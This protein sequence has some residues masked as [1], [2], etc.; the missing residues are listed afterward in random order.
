M[1]AI[2]KALVANHQG[3]G[4]VIYVSDSTF[5]EALDSVSW[6]LDDVGL[7]DA[8]DGISVWEGV[9]QTIWVTKEESDFVLKGTFRQP[10]IEEWNHLASG[11]N[12]WVKKRG[13]KTKHDQF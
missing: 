4:I 8:P 12:P 1:V 9:M 2:R 3:T 6:K 7:D 10:T 11:N 5:S 13:P